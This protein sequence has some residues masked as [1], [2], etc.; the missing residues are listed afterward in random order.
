F[1]KES[2]VIYAENNKRI[3]HEEQPEL[4]EKVMEEILCRKPDMVALSAVYSSQAFYGYA[5]LKELKKKNIKTILGGPAVN[6]KLREVA[7]LTLNNEVELLEEITGVKID[8]ATLWTKE[9]LDFSILEKKSLPPEKKQE[10][11]YFTPEM[12]LPLRTSISCYYQQCT[13]CT[14]H[15]GKQ[16][17]ELSLQEMKESILASGAKKV[18]FIDDM[19]HKKRLLEIA[20]ILGPLQVSWIC[21]LRP[22]KDLDAETLMAL[23]DGG[24]KA[25]IWGL[26]SGSDRILQ[27]MKKG[28]NIADAQ[29]VLKNSAAAGIK[30]CL[31][32]LFG[33]PTE[34]R[35]EFK[36]TLNFIRKQKEITSLVL[37]TIFGLQHGAPILADLEPYGITQVD[38][39]ERTM[40]EPKISYQVKSG[41]TQDEATALR[42]RYKKFLNSFPYPSAMNFFRE[43]ILCVE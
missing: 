9:V 42:K 3:I 30:N 34:T 38:F 22:M 41:L 1:L 32:I 29:I 13:F 25:V 21:Q 15:A 43:H 14:H 26:E 36:E 39:K 31:Y 28:T 40:L 18:F 24:L 5:L 6:K 35:E 12:V 37:S 20:K 2:A 16:Y 19:I 11:L 17:R 27:L 33:F 23:H 8:H 10:Y 7:S 4:F